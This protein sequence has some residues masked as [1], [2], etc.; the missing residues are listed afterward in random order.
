M[1]RPRETKLQPEEETE[2]AEAEAE[3]EDEVRA[4]AEE[5]AVVEAGAATEGGKPAGEEA[6]ENE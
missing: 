5:A 6:E 2:E 3:V 1:E 4:K